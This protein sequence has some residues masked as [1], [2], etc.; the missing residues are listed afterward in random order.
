MVRGSTPR[1]DMV[2][3]VCPLYSCLTVQ[4]VS[5]SRVLAFPIGVV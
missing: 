1:G 5:S 2:Y 4:D 3:A